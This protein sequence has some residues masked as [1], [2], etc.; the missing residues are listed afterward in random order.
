MNQSVDQYGV[1]ARSCKQC[2]KSTNDGPTMYFQQATKLMLKF[3]THTHQEKG[4][5]ET[6]PPAQPAAGNCLRSREVSFLEMRKLEIAMCRSLQFMVL[7]RKS[8]RI[9]RKGES[10]RRCT[11]LLGT[12]HKANILIWRMFMSALMKAAM[13][14]EP[15]FFS[16]KLNF[17]E[18]EL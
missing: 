7:W 10:C 3:H 15:E 13:H 2:A 12:K 17:Q 5:E 9:S 11:T 8:S 18:H 1:S 4:C 16:K 14:M 6:N